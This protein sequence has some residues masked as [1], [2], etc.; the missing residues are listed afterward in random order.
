MWKSCLN[1]Q[2][3]KTR[4]IFRSKEQSLR[5]ESASRSSRSETRSSHC[6]ETQLLLMHDDQQDTSANDVFFFA[7][8]NS[9]PTKIVFLC[10][11]IFLPTTDFYRLPKIAGSI[12]T[13]HKFH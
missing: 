5:N 7:D 11:Q 12:S 4:I 2:R 3:V 1:L 6:N 10:R 13:I 8:K 9:L